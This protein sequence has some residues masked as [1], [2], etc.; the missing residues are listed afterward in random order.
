MGACYSV[1]DGDIKHTSKVDDGAG[2]HSS[3]LGKVLQFI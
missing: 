2:K 3:Y 1:Y